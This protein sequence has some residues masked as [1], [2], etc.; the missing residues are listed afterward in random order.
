MREEEILGVVTATES[1]RHGKTDYLRRG[2]APGDSREKP[3]LANAVKVTLGPK[4]RSV[5]LDKVSA[6][7]HHQDGVTVAKEIELGIRSEHGRPDGPRRAS[8]TSDIANDGFPA[9]SRAARAIFRE[10]AK[11]SSPARTRWS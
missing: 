1:T 3:A 10:G 8:K 5:V 2:V 6:P 11:N 4:G 9:A 7:P